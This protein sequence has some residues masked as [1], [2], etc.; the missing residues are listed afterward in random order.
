MVTAAS[1]VSPSYL[2]QSSRARWDRS[3]LV[4][5]SRLRGVSCYDARASG[6]RRRIGGFAQLTNQ[7]FCSCSR[8]L[9]GVTASAQ[10][11]IWCQRMQ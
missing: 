9:C 11:Q 7:A 8:L 6:C 3:Q 5:G 10:D 2:A 4:S 1:V